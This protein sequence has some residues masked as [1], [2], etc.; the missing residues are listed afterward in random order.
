MPQRV[1]VVIP[2][3]NVARFLAEAVDHVL[4]QAYPA[5]EVIVVND[6]SPD[7]DELDD[8]MARY[9]GLRE[10]RYLDRENGGPSAA[11]NTGIRAARGEFIA[12]LDGDDYWDP[13]Y[14]ATQ[15]GYLDADPGLDLVYCDARLFG[16]GPLAGRTFMASAPSEGEPT[17]ANLIAMRCAIPTT[18]VVA[19][20]GADDRRRPLR[21]AVPPLRGL[22]PV[23]PDER[24]RFAHDLPPERAGLAPPPRGQRGG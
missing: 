22:R 6:G 4:A 10:V 8:V 19:R 16:G 2:A 13:G 12:L 14:L 20:P 11:R 24:S 5:R 3:W 9:A 1:S 23:A 15:V 17:L 21:R 7:T 18:C